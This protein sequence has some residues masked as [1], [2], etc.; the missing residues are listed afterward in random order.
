MHESDLSAPCLLTIIA[1]AP[2]H[3]STHRL[4]DE[5]TLFKAIFI[6][7]N[8]AQRKETGSQVPPIALMWG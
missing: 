1:I 4:G 5:S 6:P 7:V 8:N 2:T 3:L